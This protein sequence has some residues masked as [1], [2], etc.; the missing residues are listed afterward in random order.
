MFTE[1]NGS[2]IFMVFD[3]GK[4][5]IHGWYQVLTSFNSGLSDVQMSNI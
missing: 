2:L 3:V 4:Y 5:A 1:L